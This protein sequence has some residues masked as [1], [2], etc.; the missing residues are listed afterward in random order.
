MN[1]PRCTSSLQL[2][3]RQTE[4]REHKVWLS[5]VSGRW[6]TYW[7]IVVTR[8]ASVNFQGWG[9]LSFYIGGNTLQTNRCSA[10]PTMPQ[11]EEWWPSGWCNDSNTQQMHGYGFP[12]VWKRE[13]MGKEAIYYNTILNYLKTNKTKQSNKWAINCVQ[14]CDD[15]SD[16]S[17]TDC[18]RSTQLLLS[19]R[20]QAKLISL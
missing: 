4:N 3:R 9:Q 15:P 7:V 5:L 14:G 10:K 19:K 11:T 1:H 2:T 13:C 17:R 18:V 20:R 12:R 16:G 8:V 6:I